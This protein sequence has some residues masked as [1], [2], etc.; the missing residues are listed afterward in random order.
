MT[1]QA[2]PLYCNAFRTLK[3]RAESG[4]QFSIAEIENLIEADPPTK[5]A[6]AEIAAESR[7]GRQ[8]TV[9]EMAT[10]CRMPEDFVVM[11]VAAF[12]GHFLVGLRKEA[13]N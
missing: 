7:A 8:I 12:V 1:D 3:R 13:V 11:L 2:T 10:R 4:H 5:K 9:A 6:M